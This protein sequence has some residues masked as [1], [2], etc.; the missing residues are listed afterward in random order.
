MDT[1]HT[2]TPY[3]VVDDYHPTRACIEVQDINNQSI[4]T[5]Y[6]WSGDETVKDADGIAREDHVRVANAAFIVTACNAHDQL[7]AAL[8]EIA[9][10]DPFK[11]SSN[12]I[13]AHRALAAVGA[14]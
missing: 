9:A 14:A 11:V 6:N 13:I 1:K 7:V 10:N 12:G 8:K 2:A 3:H 5:L 4:A